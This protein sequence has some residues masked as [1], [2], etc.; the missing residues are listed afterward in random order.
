MIWKG[1]RR[2]SRKI[3]L[4]QRDEIMIRFNLIDHEFASKSRTACAWRQS[5]IATAIGGADRMASSISSQYGLSLGPTTRDG[6]GW[7][8]KGD[9]SNGRPDF[10]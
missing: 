9:W 4:K 8:N 1:G 5:K 2:L 10:E 3:T 7:K 6:A